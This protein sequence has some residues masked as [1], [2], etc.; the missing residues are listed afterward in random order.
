MRFDHP[1]N[2]EYW[3]TVKDAPT[4]RDILA[5]DGAIEGNLRTSLYPRLWAGVA[6]LV[7]EWHV[8]GIEPDADMAALMDNAADIALIETIKWAALAVFTYRRGLEPEKN[9]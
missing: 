4:M 5:Y 7:D 3:F 8:E 9:S 2:K 6:W 1:D